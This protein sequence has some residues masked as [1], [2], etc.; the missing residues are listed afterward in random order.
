M[1]SYGILISAIF[2]SSTRRTMS[3]RNV[4]C[5]SLVLPVDHNLIR[6][7][8]NFVTGGKTVGSGVFIFG[9]LFTV[10]HFLDVNSWVSHF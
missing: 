6:V 5:M 2:M 7:P 4:I 9:V 1:Y 10:P 8:V 3:L